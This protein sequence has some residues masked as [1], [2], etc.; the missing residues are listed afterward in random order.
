MATDASRCRGVLMME[1]G[2]VVFHAGMAARG[3]V[4]NPGVGDGHELMAPTLRPGF[5][6]WRGRGAY[7]VGKGLRA[8]SQAPLPE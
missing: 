7:R 2:N 6:G 1:A 8:P 4:A 3:V 5:A